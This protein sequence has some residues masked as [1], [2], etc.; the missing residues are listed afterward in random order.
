MQKTQIKQ[1]D[2]DTMKE[3]IEKY[4]TQELGQPI[5]PKDCIYSYHKKYNSKLPKLHTLSVSSIKQEENKDST[6]S[7]AS[8]I[9][10]T[11]PKFLQQSKLLQ[12]RMGKKQFS[13]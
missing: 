6:L 9:T 3:R 1:I 11:P 5:D 7:F 2:Y 4:L 12:K 8:Q 10:N 13:L